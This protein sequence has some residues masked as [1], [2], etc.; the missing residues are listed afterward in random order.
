[1][2][3]LPSISFQQ[4][5]V[6]QSKM[7]KP[8][9]QQFHT[10]ANYTMFIPG[11]QSICR[12]FLEPRDVEKTKFEELC[13]V[14]VPP[15]SNDQIENIFIWTFNDEKWIP[16]EN[17]IERN[18]FKFSIAFSLRFPISHSFHRKTNSKTNQNIDLEYFNEFL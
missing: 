16:N 2:S 17:Y 18:F 8:T 4:R 15:I 11:I 1:M 14:Q 12:W 7:F 10:F 9:I 6:R 5:R 3:K 13:S